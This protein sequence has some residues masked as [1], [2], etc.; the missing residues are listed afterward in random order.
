MM[1]MQF[2]HF[3][4]YKS[5]GAFCCHGNQTKG[6]IVKLLAIWI[7]LTQATFLYQISHAAPVFLEE[8]SFKNSF[9]KFKCCHG[10]QTKQPL[11]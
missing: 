2:N 6:Q 11:S 5:I 3:P 7:A 10:N 4:H 1:K 9:L 8:L